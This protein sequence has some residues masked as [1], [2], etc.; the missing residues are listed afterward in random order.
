MR[1]LSVQMLIF[2]VE[3]YFKI[4]K[5][6]IFFPT[7][8]SNYLKKLQLCHEELKLH[9]NINMF[10]LRHIRCTSSQFYLSLLVSLKCCFLNDISDFANK[11]FKC[12]REERELFVHTISEV[13]LLSESMQRAMLY[14]K[15]VSIHNRCL[16]MWQE[17]NF[18]SDERYKDFVRRVTP[19][20]LLPRL[21]IELAFSNKTRLNLI[22]PIVI[23]KCICIE[24]TQ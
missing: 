16:K 9:Q 18:Y 10:L 8:A 6:L 15:L 5:Q 23:L 14:N 2:E 21:K 17:F 11:S 7:R 12:F 1:A 4:R 19:A 13:R 24:K 20:L 22:L 3:M